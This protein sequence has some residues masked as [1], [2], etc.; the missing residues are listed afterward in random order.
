LYV[1]VDATATDFNS[2]S[3]LVLRL[4]FNVTVPFSYDIINF[5]VN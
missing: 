1:V 4:K 2:V 5:T 3:N